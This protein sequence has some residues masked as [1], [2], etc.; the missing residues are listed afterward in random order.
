MTYLGIDPGHEGAIAVIRDGVPSW[1][2]MPVQSIRKGRKEIDICGV[3]QIL[4]SHVTEEPARVTIEEVGVE[5]RFGVASA[6][7]FGKGYGM[8][9]AV[10]R[11]KGWSHLLVRPQIWKS[12]MLKGT[13]KSKEAAIAKVKQLYPKLSLS[14]SPGGKQSHDA[15]EAILMALYGMKEDETV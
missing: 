3:D 8:I 7:T 2:P 15:A 6:F 9:L 13:D 4:T 10:I 5:P 11:L 1:Y 12:A 14:I